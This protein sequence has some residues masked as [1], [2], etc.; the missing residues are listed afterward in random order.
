MNLLCLPYFHSTFLHNSIS[1]FTLSAIKEQ[2]VTLPLLVATLNQ[3]DHEK[4]TRQK[5]KRERKRDQII[6]KLTKSNRQQVAF[7]QLS[8]KN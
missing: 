2:P 3:P 5:R 8:S 1:K 7:D 6:K 4:L